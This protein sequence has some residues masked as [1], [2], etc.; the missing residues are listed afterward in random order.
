MDPHVM[1][2][3]ITPYWK[4]GIADDIIFKKTLIFIFNT[5]TY[6]SMAH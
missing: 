1:L 4:E 5:N 3:Y 6:K 2:I